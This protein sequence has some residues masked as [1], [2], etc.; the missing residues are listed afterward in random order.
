[1]V[2]R[3]A[4]EKVVERRNLSLAEAEEAM[5]AIMAGEATPAQVGAFL[6]GMRMKGET[7]EEITGFARAM[8]ARAR[9]L[10]P[11]RCQPVDTCGTGGDRRFTFNISTA[12]AFVVAGAGVPVAKHGNRSVSS[13]CGSAD[14]LEAL[15]ARLDLGPAE[16]H[17]CL[18]E[19][20]I[21]FLFAPTFHEAMKHAAGPRREVG[22]RTFFNLLGPLTN[23]AGVRAQ[24]V[25]VYSPEL[26]EPV[27]QVLAALGVERALVVHGEDGLDEITVTG[28]TRVTELAQGQVCTY[29]LE[30]SHF[31]VNPARLEDLQGSTSEENARLLRRVLEGERGPRRDI[32]LANAA[33]ALFVSGAAADLREGVARAA[34]AIDSG[35]ALAKLEQF[36]SFTRRCAPGVPC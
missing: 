18:E 6:I 3:R 32:V 30:P 36:V 14:V 21:C 23:P 4:I 35:A 34:H 8:R 2:L 19:V 24:V 16:A 7:V 12:V 20:G 29:Y 33:A 26:T 28:R 31:G 10:P 25:G 9:K 5:H 11:T 17:A 22:T 27:A 15:G 1:M 13:R